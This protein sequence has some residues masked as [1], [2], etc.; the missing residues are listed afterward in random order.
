M[1]LGAL[2]GGV[3]VTAGVL[4][5]VWLRLGFPLPVCHF[6]EWTGIPCPTCGSTRMAA[7]L[8]SGDIIGAVAW[9]PLVFVGLTGVALWAAMSTIRLVFGLPAW[10]FE[11]TPR[12]SLTL[13]ILVVTALFVGWAYLIWRG[14]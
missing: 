7:T 2:F 1:I 13:R 4:A 5:A 12:E 8:L 9:N 3:L 11:L 10:R 14:T 6:R